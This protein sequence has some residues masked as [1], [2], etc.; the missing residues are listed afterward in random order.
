M[1]T[2][3]IDEVAENWLAERLVT[4]EGL[5][6]LRKAHK[7]NLSVVGGGVPCVADGSFCASV[8]IPRGSSWGEAI[9]ALLDTVEPGTGGKR[10]HQVRKAL[11]LPTSA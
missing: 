4:P 9:A 3:R 5:G 10:L 6:I 11:G 1:I 8:D 7:E 2:T